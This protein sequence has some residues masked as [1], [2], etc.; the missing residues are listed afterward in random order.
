MH[1]DKLYQRVLQHEVAVEQ[2]KKDGTPVPKFDPAV[3]IPRP[4]AAGADEIQPSDELRAQWREKLDQLPEA[5]R[6]VEEAALR[7][8]LQT[9]S[10][11]ARTMKEYYGPKK[12]TA[13][14]EGGGDGAPP[15]GDAQKPQ[16]KSVADTI[17]TMMTGR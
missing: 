3:V 11:V 13:D 10:G 7:A 15:A 5:E 17:V 8:D 16:Q 2:A 9:K 6:A 4:G 12:K 14:K 1:A